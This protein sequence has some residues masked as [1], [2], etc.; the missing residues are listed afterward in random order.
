MS[1]TTTTDTP[2]SPLVRGL[3]LLVI[4]AAGI[5]SLPLAAAPMDGEGSENWIIPL[6]LVGMAVVGAVVGR[7]TGWGL[8]RGAAIGLACAVVGVAIFFVLLNGWDGA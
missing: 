1:D 3:G 7:L 4:L 8:A 6:Q 5:V 2:A